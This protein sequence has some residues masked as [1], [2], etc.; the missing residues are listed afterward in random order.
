MTIVLSILFRQEQLMPTSPHYLSTAQAGE[1]LGISR[2]HVRRLIQRGELHAEETVN[3]FL[4]IADDVAFLA[5]KRRALRDQREFRSAVEHLSAQ[6]RAIDGSAMI[7]NTIATLRDQIRMYSAFE[8]AN[9]AAPG[10]KHLEAKIFAEASL[11]ALRKPI[12]VVAEKLHCL[13]QDARK[14]I[15]KVMIFDNDFKANIATMTGASKAALSEKFTSQAARMVLT[16]QQARQF[17][18]ADPDAFG[19]RAAMST[20]AQENQEGALTATPES[21]AS[22][23]VGQGE[24]ARGFV[25][26]ESHEAR[27]EE[28]VDELDR[29]VE[30]L[31]ELIM[32]QGA[33]PIVE[34]PTWQRWAGSDRPEDVLAKLDAIRTKVTGGKRAGE[35]STDV[36]REAR[37]ARGRGE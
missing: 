14:V 7:A 6:A 11:T 18:T 3:G 9:V 33:A 21:S 12:N 28:K 20:S 27:L 8:L 30:Q 5:A 17:D 25:V 34:M 37:E 36:I 15:G 13:D 24:L 16:E 26:A 31:T 35:N 2:E 4:L 22:L 10:V 23:I 1:R 19:M 29:K 32:R